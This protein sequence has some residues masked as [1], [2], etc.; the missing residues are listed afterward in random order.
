VAVLGETEWGWRNID[1]RPICE[2]MPPLHR[3]GCR[4]AAA[5]RGTDGE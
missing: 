1:Q 3:P 2:E 5:L 4:L